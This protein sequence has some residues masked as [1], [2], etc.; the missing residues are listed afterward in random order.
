[1]TEADRYYARVLEMMAG[2]AAEP[3]ADPT[4]QRL[5]LWQEQRAA[6]YEP[7][8]V[9]VEDRQ[10]PGPHGPI[11]VRIYRPAARHE[12]APLLV[13]C[14]G[15]GWHRGGLEMRE[16]D[17]TSREVC[18]RADAVV[19]SVDYRLAQQGVHFPIPHDDVVAAIRWAMQ[20]TE[21]LGASARHITV[22]GG[23]AGANL[24][25]GAMLRLRDEGAPLPALAALVYPVLH[26]QSPAPSPQLAEVLPKLSPLMGFVPEV[27]TPLVENYLGAPLDAAT[28]YAFAGIGELDGLPPVY[29]LNSEYDGLRASS[30]KFARQ[31]QS[32]GVPVEVEMISGAF[33]GALNRPGLTVAHEGYGML[34]QRVAS[35]GE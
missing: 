12:N 27:L 8:H 24:V 10:L 23:S 18:L 9:D 28:P 25:A 33:H 6:D 14:H 17:A 35:A 34:A 4:L 15:G 1:M 20:H 30:E 22:G 13:W 7:P 19:V 31:L 29:I 11:P 5:S 2:P 21:E 32:A 26:P 3:N 16:A